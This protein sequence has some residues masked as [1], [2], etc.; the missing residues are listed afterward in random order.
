M[1]ASAW[2]DRS[3]FW[4]L[5]VFI[6]SFMAYW[7][8]MESPKLKE[9]LARRLG[10]ERGALWYFLSNKAWGAF[11]FGV[12]CSI[13][14]LRIFPGSSLPQMGLAWPRTNP[15]LYLGLTLALS[16]ALA[17]A[18]RLRARR[19]ALKGGDFGRYPEIRTVRWTWATTALDAA[20]WSLYLFGYELLF[21][22]TLLFPL[23]A[24]LGPWTAA[25][26]NAALYAA[27]HIP[28]GPAEAIGALFLGLALC[29]ITLASGS[30]LPAFAIHAALAISNDLFAHSFRNGKGGAS[31]PEDRR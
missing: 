18:N 5:L 27:V 1:N 4:F 9:R 29:P 19:I 28:K 6:S 16:A 13:A 26:I 15:G 2:P 21:R 20:F 12:L 17:G 30:M 23:A 7:L 25:G 8:P 22:G 11:L 14:A 24:M 31:A 10:A 3:A